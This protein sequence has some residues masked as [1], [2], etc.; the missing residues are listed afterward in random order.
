M[1]SFRISTIETTTIMEGVFYIIYA[2]FR[3]ADCHDG[4]LRN[5]LEQSN[6][7]NA[8]LNITGVLLYNE[9]MFV[10]VL[11]GEEYSVLKL[12]EKIASD[13]RHSSPIVLDR[14]MYDD[15]LFPEWHMAEKKLDWDSL[16]FKST[17]DDVVKT[18]FLCLLNGYEGGEIIDSIARVMK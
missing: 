12:Y 10:Q 15:R 3:K 18:K 6:V 11:E 5:I 2:S 7:W 9:V 4:V 17:I 1:N 8:R 16:K 13:N 14:G